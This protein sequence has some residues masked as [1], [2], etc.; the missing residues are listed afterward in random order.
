MVRKH[1]LG[2]K[3][4]RATMEMKVAAVVC[5][6]TATALEGSVA[7]IYRNEY[8]DYVAEIHSDLTRFC[9]RHHSNFLKYGTVATRKHKGR[10]PKVPDDV[11]LKASIIFKAGK[12]VEAYPY[13]DAERK[14]EV[15]VWWTSIK[16]ACRECSDLQ[17]LCTKYD[18]TPKQLLKRMRAV[19]PKLVRRRV[20][21]K[22]DLTAEQKARRKAAAEKLY[23]MFQHDPDML[24]R[25]YFIDECKIWMSDLAAGA[26][27]VY[28]DAHD[29]NVHAVLP[30]KWMRKSKDNKPVKLHFVCAVNPVHGAVYCKFTTGTTDNLDHVGNPN[31]PYYVSVCCYSFGACH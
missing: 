21:V 24:H 15:H 1:P 18:I 17:D 12:V 3:S 11:A 6:I 9:I 4:N 14:T 16:V 25:I 13:A 23:K 8:P 19:D 26:V 7:G 29:A 10:P 28:C 22:M 30:C 2:W 20:D 31:T 5:M 27:K